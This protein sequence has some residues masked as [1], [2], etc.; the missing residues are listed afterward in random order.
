MNMTNE[1]YDRLRLVALI[2]VPATTCIVAILSAL[3]YAHTDVVAAILAAIDTF[4]GT[5]VEIV[6]REYNKREEG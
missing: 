5:L 1:A 4:L 2:A 6:R 3:G